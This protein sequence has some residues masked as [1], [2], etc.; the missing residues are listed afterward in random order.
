MISPDIALQNQPE[1][2]IFITNSLKVIHGIA[3]E[4]SLLLHITQADTKQL[5]LTLLWMTRRI[6]KLRGDDTLFYIFLSNCYEEKNLR[7]KSN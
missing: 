6:F 2:S 4:G 5:A 1:S 3:E 7:S